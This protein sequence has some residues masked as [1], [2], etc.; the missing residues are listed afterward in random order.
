[1]KVWS[2]QLWLWF[3][4]NVFG[5]SM[6]FEPMASALALQCSNNWAMKTHT[7][8][9]GQFVE[10]IVPVKRMKHEYYVNCGHTNEMKVWSSQLWLRFNKQLQLSPKN[11]FG[12]LMGFEPMA[13][14]LELQCSTNWAMKTHTLE[15]GQFLEFIVPWKE[16]NIWILCELRTYKWNEGVIIAVVIV[17]FTYQIVWASLGMSSLLLLPKYHTHLPQSG[18]FWNSNNFKAN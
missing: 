18:N 4:Q 3:K 13:S 15:A 16:W 6:G 1:M 17:N 7:L 8:G 12:A 2:S 9:A 10:S 14:A 11:V 5:A